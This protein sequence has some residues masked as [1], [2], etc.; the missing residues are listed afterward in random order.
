MIVEL[1]STANK[2]HL[3]LVLKEEEQVL[4]PKAELEKTHE[5]KASKKVIE[6]VEGDKKSSPLT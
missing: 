1:V 3:L 5:K 4:M 6:E 2:Y